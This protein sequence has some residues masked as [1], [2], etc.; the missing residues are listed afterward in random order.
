MNIEE[1]L[2]LAQRIFGGT[3]VEVPDDSRFDPDSSPRYTPWL[4]FG[5]Y[6]G[7]PITSVPRD[8]LRWALR[9]KRLEPFERRLI[10][11]ALGI[12]QTE[13][14]S[15]GETLALWRSVDAQGRLWSEN[16]FWRCRS[17][18][19]VHRPWE[20][21]P[22]MPEACF[23]C[24]SLPAPPEPSIRERAAALR[25][26]A[27][28][29]KSR[30]AEEEK[31]AATCTNCGREFEQIYYDPAGRCLGCALRESE[32]QNLSPQNGTGAEQIKRTKS[33]N[34]HAKET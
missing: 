10:E 14:P 12:E 22:E 31:K 8:Y 29:R 5:R 13:K 3:T 7:R 20:Y 28:S 9:Q 16:A 17:C 6:R 15:L 34:P 27:A 23:A 21:L 33:V 25:T 2:L 11:W 30:P 4:T 24:S 18:S 1:A 19:R 32:A 26:T